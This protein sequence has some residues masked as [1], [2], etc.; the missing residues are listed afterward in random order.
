MIINEYDGIALEEFCK[1]EKV[2]HGKILNSLGSLGRIGRQ[3]HLV[4]K[5]KASKAHHLIEN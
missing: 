2:R 4:S 3:Y 5:L 1:A